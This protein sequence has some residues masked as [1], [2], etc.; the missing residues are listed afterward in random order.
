VAVSI[1]DMPESWRA[2]R[3]EDEAFWK[4]QERNIQGALGQPCCTLSGISSGLMEMR[5]NLAVVV[6]GEDE[7][8]A[9][10][11]HIGPNKINFYCTGLTEREFVTGR[12]QEPLTRCLRAVASE[13]KPEA[14]FVLGACPVEVIGDT[15]EETVGKVQKEFP[16]IPMLAL[17]TS[18][19]KVGTQ[20]AM[21]DWMFQSLASLPTLP[22]VEKRWRRT[23]SEAGMELVRASLEGSPGQVRST[24]ENIQ[25]IPT[26]IEMPRE[27]CVTYIG[28][29]KHRSLDWSPPESIELLERVGLHVIGNF[30]LIATFR[31]WR[32]IRYAR[33]G[34]V[35][36]RSL[37]PKL[38]RQL[39]EGG[40]KVQEIPLPVGI[41]QTKQ[42][43][44]LIGEACGVTAELQAAYAP[45][46]ERAEA[47]VEALK[48]RW[49]GLKV[50]YGIRML[51]NYQ[52]DQLAYQGLGDHK[53]LEEYGFDLTLLVQGPPDKRE[54]FKQMFERRNIH[55]PFDMF[56][57]PWV[58][59][60][61]LQNGKYDAAYLADHCRPEAQ[62]AGVPMIT[63]RALE[64]YF[65]GVVTNA[66]YVDH[67]LQHLI[68]GS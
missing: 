6:H 57:E 20:Q 63:S 30:P 19:L 3:A 27:R 60:E 46:L 7:C 26:Q 5:G 59:G 32:S 22:P 31:D 49:G 2:L 23:A 17:H 29:P 28:L 66:N 4:D 25:A 18:G 10:F 38:I 16:D 56:L 12:T 39:E 42:M 41:A 24:L 47:R 54:K 62:K 52:A 61:V 48:K 9:C 67:I 13:A 35:A 14:I 68:G 11:R 34:F 58:I 45:A 8:A 15:F 65:A 50:A 51:N 36:D 44:D 37:Y 53:A 21:L 1:D 33:H 55:L 43:Y 64:P 40:Q